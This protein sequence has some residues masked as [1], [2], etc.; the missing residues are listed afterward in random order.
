MS[1]S[2]SVCVHVCMSVCIFIENLST[3]KFHSQRY[4]P[5]K[6]VFHSIHLPSHPFSSSSFPLLFLP[7]SYPPSS[8]FPFLSLSPPPLPLLS[9]SPSRIPQVNVC[10]DIHQSV[11]E[12][13]KQF[14]AEL[15]R[16]NY[17][18]P[19]SYLELLSTFA[20]LV[21]IKASELSTQRNRTKSGL[22]KVQLLLFI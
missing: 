14:K 3:V 16:H 10:V 17:V 2:L 5:E 8:L 6:D 11:V 22:D 18:T 7:S 19:T 1:V 9:P 13:S 15:S 20:K 12:K 21:R 4:K